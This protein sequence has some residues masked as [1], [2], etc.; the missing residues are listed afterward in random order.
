MIKM[1]R[2]DLKKHGETAFSGRGSFLNGGR[3]NHF[4]IPIV[5]TSESLSLATLEKFV[6]LQNRNHPMS[7]VELIYTVAIA[8]DNVSLEDIS[9]KRLPK[10]WD[11]IPAIN[12]TKDF[13]TMWYREN[14]TAL[15][16][17]RSAVV[18]SEFNYLINPMHPD[19]KK[20]KILKP[21]LFSFDSRMMLS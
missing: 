11:G 16:K 19:F 4:K 9:T 10:G 20:I 17:V 1:Y 5:Y 13:G 8:T 12:Y 14:R 3:W 6:N 2:I 18:T 15:L 21:D 7:K